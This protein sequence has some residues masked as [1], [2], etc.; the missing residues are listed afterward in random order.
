MT[1]SDWN[2]SLRIS[3]MVLSNQN[4]VVKINRFIRERYD[5]FILVVLCF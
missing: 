2:I 4:E 1:A 5:D 3:E